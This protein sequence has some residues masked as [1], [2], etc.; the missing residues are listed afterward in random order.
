MP[1]VKF[2]S[3]GKWAE[4]NPAI[5]QFEVS[6]DEVREVSH[7]LAESI[8]RAGKG[9]IVKVSAKAKAEDDPAKGDKDKA[10]GSKAK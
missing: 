2:K 1:H 5:P 7:E 4:Y 9:E 3:A 6:K 10:E 8:V